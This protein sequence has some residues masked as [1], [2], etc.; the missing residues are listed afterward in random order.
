MSPQDTRHP[1]APQ[2]SSSG[3]EWLARLQDLLTEDRR[4][5]LDSVLAR[6]TR[7]LTLVLD[8]IRQEHNVSAVLRSAEAFGIQDVY[9][10][11]TDESFQVTAKVAMGSH[12][13]LTLHRFHGPEASPA[14]LQAL[15]AGGYRLAATGPPRDGAISFETLD[16][17]RP[18][19][20]ALGNERLGLSPAILAA[21]ECCVTI[22]MQGFVESLNISVAAAILL[23]QL[24]SRLRGSPVDWRLT[25]AERSE[26]LLDWTR[27]SI[28]SV[29]LIEARWRAAEEAR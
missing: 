22:P 26:L 9:V 21:A 11:E 10:I 13:W 27:K 15:Q 24:T 1:P 12:R 4:R 20:I 29:D 23:Q 2:G 28:P 25:E 5:R 17:D 19:A 8:D 3:P 6:R 14:C 18:L 16:F 7:R